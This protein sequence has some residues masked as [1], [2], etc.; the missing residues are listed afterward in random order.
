MTFTAPGRAYT[1]ATFYIG[2]S[3]IFRMTNKL[4]VD[5]YKELGNGK[6]KK[7][8]IVLEEEDNSYCW[9]LVILDINQQPTERTG[10]TSAA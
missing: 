7:V 6:S 8:I 4:E 10:M 2:F 9:R 5:I 3:L 1:N